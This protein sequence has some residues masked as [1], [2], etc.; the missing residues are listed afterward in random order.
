MKSQLARETTM[1][2][3]KPLNQHK[4]PMTVSLEPEHREWIREHYREYGFRSESHAVDAAIR[5]L[6]E[7]KQGEKEES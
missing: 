7:K 6:I 3:R 5:L 2:P 1:P 4:R